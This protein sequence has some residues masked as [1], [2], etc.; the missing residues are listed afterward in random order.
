[1][2]ASRS[3]CCIQD[4]FIV[5]QI[6]VGKHKF[7]K[8]LLRCNSF[9]L[10][11]YKGKYSIEQLFAFLST[12]RAYIQINLIFIRLLHFE[13]FDIWK[14]VRQVFLQYPYSLIDG[15]CMLSYM[16]VKTQG[17]YIEVC[18]IMQTKYESWRNCER[19]VNNWKKVGFWILPLLGYDPIGTP[20]SAKYPSE[21]IFNSARYSLI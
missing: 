10:P 2:S 14:R 21:R 11:I 15:N 19:P 20:L 13:D 3:E 17:F 5:I 16:G 8:I 12:E 9:Y 18:S 1:M 4:Q 7:R 6:F